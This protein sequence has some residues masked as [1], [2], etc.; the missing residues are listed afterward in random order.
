MAFP[1]PSLRIGRPLIL[2]LATT[3]ALVP[4]AEAKIIKN[5]DTDGDGIPNYKDNNIDGLPGDNIPGVL[6]RD[7]LLNWQDDDMDGDT[8]ANDAATEVDIDGDGATDDDPAEKDIDCDFKNNNTKAEKDIDGDFR[9]DDA[10]DEADIDGDGQL[11]TVDSDMDADGI[12][13]TKD[14][15][16]D[17]DDVVNGRNGELDTDGDGLIDSADTDDD[18]DGVLDTKDRDDDAD[19]DPDYQDTTWVRD[20]TNRGGGTIP[21]PD[22]DTNTG[23]RPTN[24]LTGASNSQVIQRR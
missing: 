6:I 5:L 11:D 17:G 19:G 9:P 22:P 15:N 16:M 4:A 21:N 8:R 18:G 24:P 12:R 7:A 14:R 3:L 20:S 2:A 13:N 10:A 23:N 1:I